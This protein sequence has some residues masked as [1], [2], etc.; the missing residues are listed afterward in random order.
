MRFR[1]NKFFLQ[2][3]LP[4]LYTT[5]RSCQYSVCQI[6]NVLRISQL[7]EQDTLALTETAAFP[8]ALLS[9]SPEKLTKLLLCPRHKGTG[10][11]PLLAGSKCWKAALLQ[12]PCTT[13]GKGCLSACTSLAAGEG[14]GKHICRWK[15]HPG[16]WLSACR[17]GVWGCEWGY[18]WVAFWGR[19]ECLV[20]TS[21]LRGFVKK[22][23]PWVSSVNENNC[24]ISLIGSLETLRQCYIKQHTAGQFMFVPE[25]WL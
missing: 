25:L 6:I 14:R 10:N 19:A 20:T 15:E 16:V 2:G 11:F 4:P 8:H 7:E 9:N 3:E 5:M 22:H 1:K 12:A 21:A 13:L 17:Q 23:F 24:A 18:R